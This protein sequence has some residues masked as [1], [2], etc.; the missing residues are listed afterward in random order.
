MN[1]LF[2]KATII[3]IGLLGGSLALAVKNLGICREI[4][5][6]SRSP[7][8]LQ[9]A[10][11]K[12]IITSASTDLITACKDTELIV[13][14]SPVSTFSS[15]CKKFAPSISPECIVT[16][17]GSVKG[18]LV[19]EIQELIPNYIGSHPIAGSERSGMQYSRGDLFQ[20]ALC[21]VTPT[22][23]TV[24]Q[25]LQKITALWRQCGCKVQYLD[26]HVH[27]AV[28]AEVSHLPHILAYAL[29]NS[30]NQNFLSFAGQ[31]FKD[32]TRIAMSSAEMWSDIAIANKSFLLEAI[33]RYTQS[34]E[35]IKQAIINDD[36]QTLMGLFNLARTKRMSM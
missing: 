25:S 22:M 18:N 32:T 9:T 2:E 15:L 19:Y 6:Y 10:L 11:Q 23:Q 14:A 4:I 26:P 35:Q 13:L 29:V 30:V 24:Q 20:N 7:E 8:T 5:G 17:V 36:A 28:F 16:D 33:T 1:Y 21:I 12:G 34:L 31:G 3:G 27:D